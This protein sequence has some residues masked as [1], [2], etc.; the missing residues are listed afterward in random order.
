[1][2]TVY[3]AAQAA[4][5]KSRL[6]QYTQALTLFE[7]GELEAAEVLLQ[8]LDAAG[9]TTPAQFLAHYTSSQKQSHQGRRAVDKTTAQGSVIEIL[10][11]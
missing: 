8:A 7:A 1:L 2:F 5:I 4:Q 11:K 9:P 3:P 6:D 10:S